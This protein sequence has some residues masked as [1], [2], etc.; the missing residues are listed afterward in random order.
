MMS[1][2]DT[3]HSRFRNMQVENR[4][5]AGKADLWGGRWMVLDSCETMRNV[6]GWS[7]GG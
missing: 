3:K 7:A 2:D 6:L 5:H 4:I 1:E